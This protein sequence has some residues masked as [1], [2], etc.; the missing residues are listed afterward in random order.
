MTIT[1]VLGPDQGE[2][3]WYQMALRA[4]VVFLVALGMIRLAGMRSFGTQSAFDVVLS[5]TLGAV[6]GSSITGEAPFFPCLGAATLL[7]LLHR[8]I[9]HWSARNKLI[10]HLTEGDPVLLFSSGKKFRK[11]MMLQ[12]ISENDLKQAIHESNLDDF[13][14]V[15]T[16]WMEPDGK[17]SVVKKE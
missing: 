6:L 17:I 11:N 3:L 8:G 15:K 9:G 16:I 10:G 7:A 2:V 4:F 12:G 13:D 1:D 14:K 5:I